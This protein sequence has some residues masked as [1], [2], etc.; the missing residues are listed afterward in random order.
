MDHVAML[1]ALLSLP[2]YVRNDEVDADIRQY[3]QA[4]IQ[5]AIANIH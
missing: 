1:E 3:V 5:F 2:P 4:L